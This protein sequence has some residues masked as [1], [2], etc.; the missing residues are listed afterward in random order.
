MSLTM[1]EHS[2]SPHVLLGEKIKIKNKAQLQI[3]LQNYYKKKKKINSTKQ[4]GTI[5]C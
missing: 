3:I 1:N 2:E 5:K 4:K